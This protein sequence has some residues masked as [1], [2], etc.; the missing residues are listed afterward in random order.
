M[1]VSMGVG[2]LAGLVL[3]GVGPYRP[4]TGALLGWN[5][6]VW[7]YLLLVVL[8][9]RRADQN[10]LRNTAL[11]QAEGAVTVLTAAVLAALASL[12]GIVA[13]LSLAKPSGAPHALPHVLFAVSTVVGSWLLMPVLFAL[14]Y[15]SRFYAVPLGQGLKFPVEADTDSVYR[16][17]YGDFFYFAFTIAVASQTS[18]VTVTTRAMR[19]LVLA[20]SLL[21][22]A[23]NTAILAFSINIAAGLL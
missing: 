7:L 13:E 9:V 16:P 14:T 5:I 19:R 15:A 1:A 4:V 6:A 10:H 22:F 17:D 23:F 12:V 3:S 20:Q 18:D 8:M 21:S 11:A 2:L